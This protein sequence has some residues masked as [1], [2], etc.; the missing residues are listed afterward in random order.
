MTKLQKIHRTD[1]IIQEYLGTTTKNYKKTILH[2]I[3]ILNILTK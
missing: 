3:L 1:N 2:N